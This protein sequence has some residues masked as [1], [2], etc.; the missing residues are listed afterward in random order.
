MKTI[1]VLILA[2]LP[3][4]FAAEPPARTV[5]D[6]FPT[7]SKYEYTVCAYSPDGRFFALADCDVLLFD[8]SFETPKG[9]DSKRYIS[10]RAV[11]NISDLGGAGMAGSLSRTFLGLFEGENVGKQ[12]VRVG[13]RGG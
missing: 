9:D 11:Q 7:A 4:A 10:Q 2:V 3:T 5:C 1:A 6:L 8:A 13:K 12:M